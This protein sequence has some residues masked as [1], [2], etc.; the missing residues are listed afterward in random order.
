[1]VHKQWKPTLYKIFQIVKL[2]ELK[3]KHL[4][5]QVSLFI[6]VETEAYRIC[7][8]IIANFL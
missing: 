1:M 6:Y 4:R 3:K 2:W 7:V 5:T 8:H